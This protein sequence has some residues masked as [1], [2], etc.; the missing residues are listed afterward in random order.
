MPW[1]L[2]I[3][4]LLVVGFTITSKAKA[5]V[6]P[7]AGER[8][9]ISLQLSSN[10]SS[11]PTSLNDRAAIVQ[12]LMTD[13]LFAGRINDTLFVPDSNRIALDITFIQSPAT[14]LGVGGVFEVMPGIRA[15]V[16]EAKRLS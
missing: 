15:T 12:A 2:A 14:P 5:A 10:N 4:A 8:W 16:I 6:L 13:L 3:A 9:A 7:Q 11:T 1:F